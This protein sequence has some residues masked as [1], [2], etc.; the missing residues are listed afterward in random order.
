MISG[1]V[2]LHCR[3]TLV[4]L[5]RLDWV[6][7]AG[8]QDPVGFNLDCVI[9][10]KEA[11][12]FLSGPSDDMDKLLHAYSS[13]ELEEYCKCKIALERIAEKTK[14]QDRHADEEDTPDS[15]HTKLEL[16]KRLRR[17]IR[18]IESNL[19]VIRPAASKKTTV[20]GRTR[21]L[22]TDYILLGPQLPKVLCLITAASRSLPAASMKP[23]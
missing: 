9:P 16:N 13:G 21:K 17:M 22:R 20:S 15:L 8:L 2:R 6:L 23:S 14:L 19:G 5:G 18:G 1:S 10:T 12:F 3:Y 7:L 4:P 11:G